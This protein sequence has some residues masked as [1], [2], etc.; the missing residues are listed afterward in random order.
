[1]ILWKIQVCCI[2]KIGHVHLK[3]FNICSQEELHSK[4][5]NCKKA[6]RDYFMIMNIFSVH[7]LNIYFS[8]LWKFQIH[9]KKFECRKETSSS[10]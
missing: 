9:I 8:N 7:Y 6:T 2:K 5:Y 1:M 3:E 4:L 10:K